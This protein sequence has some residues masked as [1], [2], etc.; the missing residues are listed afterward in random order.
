MT[1][2]KNTKNQ[3]EGCCENVFK[4]L[5]FSTNTKFTLF[6]SFAKFSIFSIRKKNIFAIVWGGE[7]K[8]VLLFKWTIL[9][10]LKI[11]LRICSTQNYVS[12]SSIDPGEP[13]KNPWRPPEKPR[14][15]IRRFEKCMRQNANSD[16]VSL[17]YFFS[18]FSARVYES[19][20]FF[21]IFFF[22]VTERVYMSFM[23]PVQEFFLADNTCMKGGRRVVKF[24]RNKILFTV[25]RTKSE[26]NAWQ[27]KESNENSQK[28]QV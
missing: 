15:S 22:K 27:R 25:S 1:K 19:L 11:F 20:V 26:N 5:A 2:I 12:Y 6:L 16:R 17:S 7:V 9:I 14:K 18:I 10:F 4:S 21:R 8:I 3:S 24:I 13:F 28:S 23:S